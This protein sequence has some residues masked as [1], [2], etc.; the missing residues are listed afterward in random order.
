M[1]EE[2]KK[3]VAD[4]VMMMVKDEMQKLKGEM[5]NNMKNDQ[6]QNLKDDMMTNMKNEMQKLK[7]EMMN[8]NMEIEHSK[9]AAPNNGE[10]LNL[11]LIIAIIAEKSALL[12][13][14]KR[15]FVKQSKLEG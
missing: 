7:D 13:Y 8:L 3:R 2:Q 12:A 10:H 14:L 9:A 1:N 5:M 6:Q 4:E 11:E 15:F